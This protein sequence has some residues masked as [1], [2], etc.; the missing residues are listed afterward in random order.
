MSFVGR[1]RSSDEYFDARVLWSDFY[2]KLLAQGNP[3]SILVCSYFKTILNVNMTL[4][5]L[6]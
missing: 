3:R 6:D 5:R 4:D 2:S 1:K